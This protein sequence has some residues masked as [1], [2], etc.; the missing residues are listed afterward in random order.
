MMLMLGCADV[1]VTDT[2]IMPAGVGA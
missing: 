1:D 2:V